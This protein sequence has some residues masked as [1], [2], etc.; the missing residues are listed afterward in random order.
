M[1][2]IRVHQFGGP[3]VLKL[4]EVPDPK[5]ARGQVVIRIHAIGVNP[6]DTYIRAGK[7]GELKFPYTPGKDAAGVIESVGEA[8]TEF[9][10]GDRVYTDVTLTGAYAEKT[11]CDLATVHRLPEPA[12][13]Q[14]G[15][16][17]G[18]PAGVAYYALFYRA[19]GKP[20]E[21]VLIHGGTGGVGVAAIQ[22]ARA[23]GFT[24]IAT[25]GD[26]KGRAFALQQGAHQAAD[27]AVTD[28]PDELK[29]LTANRGIDIILEMLANQNLAK[30]L[31][32]LNKRGRVM[33]IGSR[34]PIE[35]DPRE[36]MKRDADI[37]G[38][39]LMNASPEEHR[40]IYA[41]ITAALESK[42]LRPVIGL[43]LPLAEAPKAHH[44]IMDGQ[45]HGKIILLP[46]P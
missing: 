30:D 46:S 44:E 5:P 1:Q 28:R 18:V 19:Q 27:H 35:I 32:V 45:S 23:A 10:I 36:A 24:V 25:A 14:Q 42:T 40:G 34:G 43:E 37:R 31:T 29:L 15:A 2:A 33:V 21:T 7:Y 22:L 16:A 39:V 3:E 26:E 12:T 6:V 4:E 9:K 20:G 11:L 13:F 17:V 38:V 41:A 8:V